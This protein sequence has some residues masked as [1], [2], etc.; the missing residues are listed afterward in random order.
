M[1]NIKARIELDLY[2]KYRF[3]MGKLFWYSKKVTLIPEKTL[4]IP[5]D[6][7]LFFLIIIYYYNYSSTYT[8][9]CIYLYPLKY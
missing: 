5:N 3:F 1:H 6:I 4:L 9:K 2:A 8:R 7:K